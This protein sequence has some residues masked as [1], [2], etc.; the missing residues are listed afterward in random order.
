M[1]KPRLELNHLKEH[2]FNHNLNSVD[3]NLTQP[4][5]PKILNLLLYEGPKLNYSQT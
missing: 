5:K 3:N 4:S 1:T 2:R